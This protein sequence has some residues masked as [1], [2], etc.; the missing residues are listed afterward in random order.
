MIT[1]IYEKCTANIILNDKR[2]KAFPLRLGQKMSTCPT[3]IL[4]YS[5][6]L[7]KRDGE[8][9]GERE[10]KKQVSRLKRKK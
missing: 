9:G 5:G 7:V 10:E 2:F 3:P 4:H 6:V 8:K 1:G